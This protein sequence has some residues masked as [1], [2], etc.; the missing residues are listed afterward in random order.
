ML[1]G[2]GFQGYVRRSD[3]RVDLDAS[4][5]PYGAVTGRAHSKSRPSLV[6][7]CAWISKEE[8]AGAFPTK[9]SAGL[10]RKVVSVVTGR[11]S[12]ACTS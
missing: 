8:V 6:T 3:C 4:R 1:R 9:V 5:E 7:A 2:C 10:T 12:F 11:S